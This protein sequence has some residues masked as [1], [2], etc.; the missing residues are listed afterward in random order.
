MES[1]IAYYSFCDRGPV[2]L[3]CWEWGEWAEGCEGAGWF[4]R[5]GRV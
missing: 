1:F 4:V 3:G 5:F 2:E